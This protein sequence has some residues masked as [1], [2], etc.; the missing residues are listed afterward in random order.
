MAVQFALALKLKPNTPA[1][2]KFMPC[3]KVVFE[4][5]SIAMVEP[6]IDCFER[7]TNNIGG[8]C[9][10]FLVLALTRDFRWCRR[11]E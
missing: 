10:K 1:V 3:A 2:P 4:D 6:K 9:T 8:K 5:G 7:I 11:Y